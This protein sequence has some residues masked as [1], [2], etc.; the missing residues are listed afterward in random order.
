MGPWKCNCYINVLWYENFFPA[1]LAVM[2]YLG[3][4]K[5]YLL[6]KYISYGLG[7]TENRKAQLYMG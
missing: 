4:L 3:F 6:W 7:F 1:G 2:K 5:V